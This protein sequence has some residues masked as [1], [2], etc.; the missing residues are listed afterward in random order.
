MEL[1]VAEDNYNEV[2]EILR[3]KR[4]YVEVFE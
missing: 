3:G 4:A 1:N 2:V